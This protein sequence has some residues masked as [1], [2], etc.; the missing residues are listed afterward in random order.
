MSC[1]L[2][3]LLSGMHTLTY[4][5]TNNAYSKQVSFYTYYSPTID[6]IFPSSIPE[7]GTIYVQNNDETKPFNFTDHIL[8]QFTYETDTVST[9]VATY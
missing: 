3:G 4:N 9:S 5:N 7:S 2:N 8:C 1:E 6:T